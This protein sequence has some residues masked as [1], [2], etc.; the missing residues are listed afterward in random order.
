MENTLAIENYLSEEQLDYLS[1]FNFWQNITD[2][3]FYIDPRSG[4]SVDDYYKIM[5]IK[6]ELRCKMGEKMEF[7]FE[8]AFEYSYSSYFPV[9]SYTKYN[10]KPYLFDANMMTWKVG[11]FLYE[12]IFLHN[13]EAFYIEKQTRGNDSFEYTTY[14]PSNSKELYQNEIKNMYDMPDLDKYLKSLYA[15]NL[16]ENNYLKKSLLENYS[17]PNINFDY[18]AAQIKKSLG[19]LLYE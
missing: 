11:L 3:A 2:K 14:D 13:F 6:N 5:N 10:I 4:T 15:E 8:E 16:F 1:N 17:D 7:N 19:M 12:Y 9:T 18:L